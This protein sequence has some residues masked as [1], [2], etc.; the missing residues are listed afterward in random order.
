M[1]SITNQTKNKNVSVSVKA[2]GCVWATVHSK[3]PRAIV[4]HVVWGGKVLRCL[5]D[6]GC[7]FE[8]VVDS[9]LS[10][11]PNKVVSAQSKH[12][13]VKGLGGVQDKQVLYWINQ[14]LSVQ[15]TRVN[16]KTVTQCDLKHLEYDMILGLPF[17][18]RL[19]PK[20]CWRT[21]KLAFE[22]FSWHQEPELLESA[23]IHAVCTVAEL[24]EQLRNPTKYAGT[25]DE[26]EDLIFARMIDV[27]SALEEE[28]DHPVQPGKFDVP[29]V[30]PEKQHTVLNP[31]L[32]DTQKRQML[33]LLEQ[34]KVNLS[35]KDNLPHA[36]TGFQKQPKDWAFRIPS[37]EGV[38]PPMHKPRRMSPVEK[39][40]CKRQLQWFVSHGFLKPSASSWASPVL[41]V[42][43][44]NGSMR[45]CV[46]Y[47]GANQAS[48]YDA[49]PMPNVLELFDKLIHARYV[50]ALDMIAGY[51]QIK[52][53]PDDRYKTA[54]TTPFGQF[55]FTVC[56][57]GLS[58]VPGHFQAIMHS[59]FGDFA[60]PDN[61][62]LEARELHKQKGGDETT[63]S[64][65]KGAPFST[66]VANL[67]DDLLIFSETWESHMEHLTRVLRR[68]EQHD[69]Y[70]NLSKCTFG[71]FETT[72]L[73]N[74]VGSGKRRPD[75][76]KVKALKDFPVPTTVTELRSWLGIANYLSAYIRDY[77]K[78]V[79]PFSELRG[80][81]KGRHIA[82][83]AEQLQA[84]YELK[85]AMA[86]TAVLRLPDF[87]KKFFLQCDASK[88]AI[89]SAL[90]QEHDGTLLPV[91]YRSRS[92]AGPEQRWHITDKELY[93]VVDATKHFRPYLRDE[94]FTIQSDHK[95]L[96]HIRT[97][98]KISDRMLRWL[99]HL[100]MFH[101]EWEYVPGEL[102]IYADLMS[103]PP[104]GARPIETRPLTFEHSGCDLCRRAALDSD[105]DR[106]EIG[107]V[108]PPAKR[109]K[110]HTCAK[111]ELVAA[112]VEQAADA[113]VPQHAHLV[114]ATHTV[115]SIEER[116]TRINSV[117]GAHDDVGTI[118]SLV[119]NITGIESLPMQRIKDAH[120]SDADCKNILDV[121]AAPGEQHHYNR[122]YKVVDGLILLTPSAPQRNWRV[123][124]PKGGGD[125]EQS[126]PLLELRQEIMKLFHDSMFEGHRDAQATY[127]RVR[128]KFFWPNMEAHCVRY[129]HTCDTCQRHKYMP[130]KPKGLLQ[131]L[132]APS[133]IPFEE[134]TTDFATCLPMSK[135]TY[136]GASYD[137]VQV[138][139]CRLSR[140]VRLMPCRTTDTAKQTVHNF[141]NHMFK[142]H[143]LPRSIVSDR[144]PKFTANFYKFVSEIL[145]IKLNMTSSHN[146]RADGLSERMVGVVTTL[147]RIYCGWHQ[148][149]W[150][151]MLGQL[152]F[153]LN[154]HVTHSRG[155]QAPFLISDGYVPHSPSDFVIPKSL[156]GTTAH[157]FAVQ[158]QHAARLAQDAILKNQD[159]MA[160]QYNGSRS[161]HTYKVGDKVLL[162]SA[163]VHPPG[164]KERPSTK[165]RAKYVGPFT[166][167]KLVG[168]NA[169]EL[170]LKGGLRNHPVFS[171][172][173]T[174]PFDPDTRVR[175]ARSKGLEDGDVQ[176]T[177]VAILQYKRRNK[178][179]MWLVK[180]EGIDPDDPTAPDTTWE[181]LDSFITS[182]GTTQLLVEFEEDR[183]RL[184][185]TL[186]Q[187][188]YSK[189]T[190][191]TVFTEQDGYQV[192]HA[193]ENDVVKKVADKL[194]VSVQQFVLQNEMRYGGNFI[195]KSKL[196]SGTQLRLPRPA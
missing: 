186:D 6:T 135:D 182:K 192:Y 20:L 9:N 14:G 148:N 176:W 51:Q 184:Q 2:E 98:P 43:K 76:D 155:G 3:Y 191:G 116:L 161:P 187:F 4:Y 26:I 183:V 166:I 169:L 89:G 97:Q 22:K 77:A 91:A 164:E 25:E 153:G 65:D 62:M 159:V 100:A 81:P 19:N 113:C 140:R 69:L 24:E 31:D 144:D 56:P 143:G 18:Q 92:L 146:P 70:C 52:V 165:L 37:K 40:E 45:M 121:L 71:F 42:R 170:A 142:M 154:K 138:Y 57:F 5:L 55:Q 83:N 28:G 63:N 134:L 59:L 35:D 85:T 94:L 11:D 194:N 103:R 147:I 102:M 72:Y 196:K 130:K 78:I 15:G 195:A 190:P 110:H 50:T 95:P 49:Q 173:S 120:A 79:A 137:A 30:P 74:I 64:T 73:G 181:P 12:I 34:F 174:K 39:A 54:I 48:T 177:P 139:V 108:L 179:H 104:L 157:D 145:G 32:E 158:Q 126:P 150:V 168:P 180:W 21:G 16:V 149:D 41:F 172:D 75:P 88:Y 27:V 66:F 106:F 13:L 141:M 17:L 8:C 58:G 87:K 7:T 131:P 96:E 175:V 114:R 53:H 129:V 1:S 111:G 80:Q 109:V 29:G 33:E 167:L 151:D 67:L 122:K 124:V 189:H 162:K 188:A 117:N 163:H 185:G 133:T 101:F 90:L 23:G 125:D 99:D 61:D 112:L 127:R 105:Q 118:A 171:V 38:D 82:L 119:A 107:P 152:E 46:D 123:I 132:P 128:E 136:T 84:F 36:E 86:S 68:L 44:K 156:E 93:A 178:R 10:L 115:A 60:K 193:R 47:R 160:K